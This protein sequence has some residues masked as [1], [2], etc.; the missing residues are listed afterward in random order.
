MAVITAAERLTGRSTGR[1]AGPK[2]RAQGLCCE[3]R[4]PVYCSFPEGKNRDE[5]ERTYQKSKKE[6]YGYF[7][8]RKQI[9]SGF[10]NVPLT[11][12]KYREK[13]RGFHKIEMKIPLFR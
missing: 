12:S 5:H 6:V 11:S 7:R 9:C 1:S 3:Q 2:P 13:V 4:S 10:S 8:F